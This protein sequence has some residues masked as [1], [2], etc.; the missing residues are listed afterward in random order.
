MISFNL[1]KHLEKVA[2]KK[3]GGKDVVHTELQLREKKPVLDVPEQI[4]EVQ[5]KKDRVDS[6]AKLTEERLEKVRTG[7]AQSLTEG[8]L[9]D[10]KSKL[11][12]HRNTEASAGD[13]GKLEEQRLASKPVEKE[14]YKPA[15]TTEK[16]GQ[17]PLVEGKD[18]LKTASTKTAVYSP[19]WQTEI[20][21]FP[22]E[23]LEGKE[24]PAIVPR[25]LSRQD[26]RDGV[27]EF[28]PE[29]EGGI[30]LED[31]DIGFTGKEGTPEEEE[32]VEH[33]QEIPAATEKEFAEIAQEEGGEGAPDDLLFD[34][35]DINVFDSGGTNMVRVDCSF[36]AFAFKD[37][38]EAAK[39]AVVWLKSQFPELSAK[40]IR[41]NIVLDFQKGKLTLVVPETVLKR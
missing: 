4:T 28:H 21:D 37:K 33:R 25:S 18:G 32:A 17:Y 30:D 40:A 41:D 9:D 14:K 1:R 13:I 16:D 27:Q 39:R 38:D 20:D 29:Q 7:S 8:Q 2:A 10:S 35:G 31:F 3:G 22:I 34:L 12:R 36:D 24:A 19:I 5:L 15:S 6:G 11:V 23:E 26:V